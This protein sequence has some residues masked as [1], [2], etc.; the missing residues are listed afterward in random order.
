MLR[1]KTIRELQGKTQKEVM[2]DTGISNDWLSK[3]E[4]GSLY[5]LNI[6]KLRLLAQYYGTTI[7][8]LVQEVK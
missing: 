8:E 4:R 5:G 1:M 2:N 6:E 3:A 7:D